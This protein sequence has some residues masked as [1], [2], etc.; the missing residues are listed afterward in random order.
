MLV[1]EDTELLPGWD[2]GEVLED[3][4]EEDTEFPSGGDKG[5][6]LEDCMRKKLSSYLVGTKERF[7]RMVVRK[8]LSSSLAR[9]SPKHTLLP[10]PNGR[11]P[12]RSLY[13]KMLVI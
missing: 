9:L 8:I 11:N 5:E 10:Q 4:C 12:T 7:W 6:V 2:K 3:D 1:K 13:Q